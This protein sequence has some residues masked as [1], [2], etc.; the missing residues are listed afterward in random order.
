[1]SRF[2]LRM[3]VALA[4]SAAAL[5]WTPGRAGAESPDHMGLNQRV[6]VVCVKWKD[7]AT[8]RMASA[9]DWVNLLNGGV[10]T[11]YQRATYNLTSFKFETPSSGPAGGWYDLG[12]AT[13]DY[14][15][16]KV[17]QDAVRLIDP[18]VDFS[19]Y[20]RVLVITNWKGFGGQG[21]GPW[22]W[23]VG[24][25]V[26]FNEL[27]DGVTVGR[28]AMTMSVVNEWDGVG[29]EGYDQGAAVIAHELGH[30]LGVPTHYADLKFYP[31]LVRD[32]ITPWD[33]MGLS[34]TMNHFLGWAKNERRWIPPGT[35]RVHDVPLPTTVD[36]TDVVVLKPQEVASNGVQIIRVPLSNP[37]AGPFSGYVVE[38]R[39][40]T[41][42]D[43]NLPAEGVLI[44][45]V[46]ENPNIILNCFV[47][48]NPAALGD[49][50]QAPLQVG[51]FFRDAGR[52]ITIRADSKSGDDYVV[53]VERLTPPSAKTDPMIIPWGAPPWESADIWIDSEKNGWD[54]YRYTDAAGA[55]DGNGDDAWVKHDNRVYVR[56]R[57]IGPGAA[58]NVRVQVFV[59][60]PPGLGDA[61]PNWNYLGTILFPALSAG[62]VV[63][64]F[65]LWNPQV[66]KHTCIK[67]VIEDDP[68]ELLTTNNTAQENVANFET[69][70]SS[71]YKPVTLAMNVFNPF[72]D[73][74][75]P[76]R[77]HVRDVPRGW[78]Y[79]VK[80][81]QMVLGPG[82]AGRVALTI[83]PS[84][85]KTFAQPAGGAAVGPGGAGQP[86]TGQGQGQGAGHP[87]HDG[88]APRGCGCCCCR[89][90][91][92]DGPQGGGGNGGGRPG[93]GGGGP[94]NFPDP[95]GE[96]GF[97]GKPKIEAL[98]PFADTWVP[99]GGVD[100]WT[101]L[102]K[103]T[104]LTCELRQDRL[105]PLVPPDANAAVAPV[106]E[107][108]LDM[109]RLTMFNAPRGGLALT[110]EIF[111]KNVFVPAAHAVPNYS[112][113]VRLYAAG[114]I[115]PAIQDAPIAVEMSVGT[116]RQ[117]L[118]AKTD[119]NGRYQVD[120]TPKVDGL[121]TVQAFF[122][123]N[124]VF[125]SSDAP[126]I[127]FNVSTT[128]LK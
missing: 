87:G 6:L 65:V 46:D 75:V 28:R 96:P 72:R 34:P 10:N 82:A 30:Q 22:N 39:K 54:V 11:L 79:E 97:I 84:G 123:G 127:I 58:T 43:E 38:N 60:D 61:G 76:V 29:G 99:I 90:A 15:F 77:F 93:D 105:P 80:P 88:P 33:V 91:H 112:S 8:T 125:E 113:G 117:T 118:H 109:G 101:N 116:T 20:K 49:N 59:N 110:D 56:I 106:R 57:N 14:D 37:G 103:P 95:T 102:C 67:A 27:I 52:G 85:A 66:D 23:T 83:F 92:G 53:R 128:V 120:F 71:P 7:E 89:G 98:I 104:K 107:F 94:G 111:L 40:R 121:W 124:R 69:S 5:A 126:P 3:F 31:N 19:Q 122:P 51:Q 48:D 62:G 63:Q 73:Q 21:G 74:T 26:E 115:T 108:G 45:R 35:P 1:M 41:N 70:A 47:Q 119:Q 81:R 9:Q 78:M 36:V 24:E 2:A 64:D 17:A 42:G 50:N 16:T 25:G 100:M 86:A 114:Q 44:T 4:G 18:N 12:Y 32:V 68:S 13:K 55:P